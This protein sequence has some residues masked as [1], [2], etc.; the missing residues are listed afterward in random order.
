MP[1]AAQL[2]VTRGLVR[3][4]PDL[5][6]AYVY[7][8]RDLS[9]NETAEVLPVGRWWNDLRWRMSARASS[10]VDPQPRSEA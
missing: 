3:L 9:G 4:L 8:D 1:D 10:L 5:A 6:G 7:L 2:V